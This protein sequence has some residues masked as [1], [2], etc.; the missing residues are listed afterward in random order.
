MFDTKSGV[1]GNN[2]YIDGKISTVI[3]YPKSITLRINLDPNN[4]EMIY[5]P[6]LIIDY[7]ERTQTIIE[8]YPLATPSFT[9]EYAMDT[10]KFWNVAKVIFIIIN[11]LFVILLIIQ[12]IVWCRT[13]SLSNDDSAKCKYAIVNFFITA[14][15]LYSYIFFWLLVIFAGYWFIFFKMEERVYLLL[16][17]LE[18]TSD[19]LPFNIL[20]AVVIVCKL[21]TIIYKIAFEQCSFDIFLIDWERP[22]LEY[23]S[24]G[25]IKKGVN[26]WRTLFLVNEFNEL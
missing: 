9:S 14:I 15:D 20:F 10:T 4:E 23:E 24:K 2:A 16:P 6:L 18:S 19:Y 26:A 12:V 5:P 21:L 7:R 3:R 11:A 8:G 17:A 22:K 1:E 25:D 13:P